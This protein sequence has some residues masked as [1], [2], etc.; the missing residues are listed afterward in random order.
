MLGRIL[1]EVSVAL[2]QGQ[3]MPTELCQRCLF[4][5]KTTKFPNAYITVSEEVALK[6]AE[7]AEKRYKK[8]KLL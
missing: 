3:V 8:G 4:L 5:I 2:K 7:E 1:R 6:Q